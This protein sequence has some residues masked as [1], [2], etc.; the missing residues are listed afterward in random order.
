MDR[1]DTFDAKKTA[2]LDAYEKTYGNVTKACELLGIA[3]STVYLWRKNDANFKSILEDVQPNEM[4]LDL[5]ENTLIQ[6]MK[7]GDTTA[8]IFI[9]KTKGK[10]RGYAQNSPQ[11]NEALEEI[12]RQFPNFAIGE[13]A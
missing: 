3:R 10:H 13:R 11:T 9:L 12:K 1:I 4:I 7:G 6:N 5:A 2:F 8:A